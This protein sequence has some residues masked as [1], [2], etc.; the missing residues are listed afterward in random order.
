MYFL[1]SLFL[2]LYLLSYFCSCRSILLGTNSNGFRLVLIHIQEG[3]SSKW[4]PL[5]TTCPRKIIPALVSIPITA[6]NRNLTT[7]T[8]SSCFFYNFFIYFL[9]SREWTI[10]RRNVPFPKRCDIS[11]RAK[12]SGGAHDFIQYQLADIHPL[13]MLRTSQLR[14]QVWYRVLKA[15]YFPAYFLT[16]LFTVSHALSAASIRSDSLRYSG[17]L[18]LAKHSPATAS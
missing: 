5:P 2:N 3:F 8:Q 4:H 15:S 9:S 13:R 1:N 11:H 7:L 17:V 10:L 18:S 12:R 6:S 16:V 14:V